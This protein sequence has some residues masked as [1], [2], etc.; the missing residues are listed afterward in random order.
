VFARITTRDHDVVLEEHDA[1]QHQSLPERNEDNVAASDRAA[2]RRDEN[3]IRV[4][5]GRMHA[6]TRSADPELPTGTHGIADESRGV[7]CGKLQ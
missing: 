3:E 2:K 1:V 7:R 5:H 4:A 6:R